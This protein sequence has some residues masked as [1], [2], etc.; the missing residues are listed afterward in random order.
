MFPWF[1]PRSALWFQ[2]RINARR[3]MEFPLL[4]RIRGVGKRYQPTRLENIQKIWKHMATP[5]RHGPPTRQG[6]PCKRW[7]NKHVSWMPKTQCATLSIIWSL[8]FRM[9]IRPGG[10]SRANNWKKHN[11]TRRN[12]HTHAKW[13][14]G[15]MTWLKRTRSERLERKQHRFAN[16]IQSYVYM[17]IRFL[18]CCVCFTNHIL[19]ACF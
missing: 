1:V 11:L 9:N 3:T 15:M 8:R 4:L 19:R 2:W 6:T 16:V 14:F 5:R 7:P 13:V 12:R 18:V 10:P 17:D